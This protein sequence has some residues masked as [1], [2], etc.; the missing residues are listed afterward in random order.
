MIKFIDD[1][2]KIERG[3]QFYQDKNRKIKNSLPTNVQL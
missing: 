2:A 1:L 3:E